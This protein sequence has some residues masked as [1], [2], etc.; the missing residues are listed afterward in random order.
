MSASPAVSSPLLRLLL[1]AALLLLALSGVLALA[2]VFFLDALAR[3]VATPILADYGVRLQAIEQIS[4]SR[5]QIRIANIRFLAPDSRDESLIK[6]LTLDF[7]PAALLEGRFQRLHIALA[8]INLDSGA[9][10]STNTGSSSGNPAATLPALPPLATL[11]DTMQA[12]PGEAVSIDS[13]RV[14]PYL[15]AGRLTVTRDARELRMLADSSDLQLDLR[16]NWQNNDTTSTAPEAINGKLLASGSSDQS[17]RLWEADSG[18]EIRRLMGYK[19]WVNLVNFSP[20]GKLLATGGEGGRGAQAVQLWE[21]AS[22]RQTK[23]AQPFGRVMSVAFHPNGRLLVYGTASG[24]ASASN[25]QV[26]LWDIG[27]GKEQ[28]RLKVFSFVHSVAFSPDGKVLAAGRFN[29][30]I[31]LWALGEGN[32]PRR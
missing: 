20:D 16:L 15:E 24:V 7:D 25:Q 2:A 4:L 21:V 10:T 31:S 14:A 29:G 30:V 18:K 6:D 23:A 11:V 22:G 3:I 27:A 19:G 28:A 8:D 9:A 5:H 32:G 12:L 1:R 26:V 17:V 13:L